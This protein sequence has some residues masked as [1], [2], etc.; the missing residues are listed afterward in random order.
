MAD[1]LI[2]AACPVRWINPL[3]AMKNGFGADEL[4]VMEQRL[5]SAVNLGNGNGEAILNALSSLLR[6]V[7]TCEPV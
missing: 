2:A 4:K 1:L 3:D 7:D 5:G 6:E